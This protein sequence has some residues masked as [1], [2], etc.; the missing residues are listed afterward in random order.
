MRKR[1][2]LPPVLAMSIVANLSD[3]IIGATIITNVRSSQ[4]AMTPAI[5]TVNSNP[6]TELEVTQR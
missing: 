2:N 4:S 5:T 6:R 1:L 3:Q